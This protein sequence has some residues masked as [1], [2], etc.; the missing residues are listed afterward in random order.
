M[1]AI[2]VFIH[3]QNHP[4]KISY[5]R[6]SKDLDSNRIYHIANHNLAK[7]NNQIYDE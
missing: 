7:Y 5:S 3:E 4:G 2:D 1:N 6:I